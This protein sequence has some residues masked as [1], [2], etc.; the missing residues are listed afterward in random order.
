MP[1]LSWGYASLPQGFDVCLPAK[2]FSSLLD[3]EEESDD[4]DVSS[5]TIPSRGQDDDDSAFAPDRAS[6]PLT[7]GTDCMKYEEG[8]LKS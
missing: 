6:P 3:N 7:G 1:G 4:S 2:Y 8:Q 5:D